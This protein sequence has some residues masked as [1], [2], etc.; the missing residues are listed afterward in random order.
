MRTRLARLLLATWV[1]VCS[2]LSL[3][4]LLTNPIVE[5]SPNTGSA[6]PSV[7]FHRG[8]YYYCRSIGN[9]QI[10]VAK[11]R[12]LQDIGAAAIVVVFTPPVGAAYS[13]RLW[14]PELQQIGHRWYI[15]F[16]A[17]DGPDPHHRMYALQ[18]TSEDPQGPY[19][20]K[21]KV[22]DRT[23]AWAIDGVVLKLNGKPYFVWSG[24]P[25]NVHFPQVLYI[26]RMRDPLTVVG[27]RHLIAVPDLDWEQTVKPLLE[28]PQPL[29]HRGQTFLV[30]SANASWSDDSALGLLSY[31]GGDP[32]LATAWK[33]SAIPL[34]TK[35]V[36]A[37]VF[38]VG[39][40][41]LTK[42]PDGREDWMLYHATDAP[43]AGW[44]ARTVR[45]QPL[46]WQPDGNP[47]LARP[48]AMGCPLQ[49]PSGTPGVGRDGKS[50]GQEF[51]ADRPQAVGAPSHC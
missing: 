30:Y 22:A 33:K 42:S 17:S 28:A 10:G 9:G 47:E 31:V 29:Y 40:A 12:R 39:H 1:S 13:K 19:I 26:A 23:D 5:A 3:A 21:G 34:F 43:G 11:A 35:N 16:A 8:H 45:A 18:S 6:D 7:V 15:Y 4:A 24:W 48:G 27:T 51:E 37:R 44:F 50:R 20:F 14:A 41:S 46:H 32:L 25:E 38:S 36:A 2:E 49:E